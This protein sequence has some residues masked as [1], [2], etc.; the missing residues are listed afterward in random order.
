VLKLALF[1]LLLAAACVTAGLYGALHNQLSY[2]VSPEYFH[3]IKFRQFS[4][5]PWLH[6]RAGA[7]LVGWHASWWMGA[8][9]GVPVLIVGLIL[10]GER[11]YLTRSLAAFG[12]VAATALVVGV[13]ALAYACLSFPGPDDGPLTDAEAGLARAGFMHDCS[14]LGGF[15][16]ILTASLYLIVERLRIARRAVRDGR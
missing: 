2:T 6:G 9:I 3:E 7:S 4:T 12:V 14:Y 5:P 10:P 16:G 11:A 8:L 15:L 1:P 13:G